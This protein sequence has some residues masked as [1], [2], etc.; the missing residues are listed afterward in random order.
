MRIDDFNEHI[1]K[2]SELI[3]QCSTDLEKAVKEL[4][5]LKNVRAIADSC[6]PHQQC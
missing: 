2:L 3:L 5:D 6:I 1:K 4:K